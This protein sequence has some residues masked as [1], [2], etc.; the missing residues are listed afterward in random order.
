MVTGI[1]PA[2]ATAMRRGFVTIGDGQFTQ[3]EEFPDTGMP[4]NY[5]NGYER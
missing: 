5:P 1:P 4:P 3:F 2:N